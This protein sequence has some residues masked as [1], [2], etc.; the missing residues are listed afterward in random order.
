MGSHRRGLPADVFLSRRLMGQI[1]E[2]A[3]LCTTIERLGV[4]VAG[5]EYM[6]SHGQDLFTFVTEAMLGFKELFF[7]EMETEKSSAIS[8]AGTTKPVAS[9][10]LRVAGPSQPLGNM[11]SRS[12]ISPTQLPLV[13]PPPK[14]RPINRKRQRENIENEN[15]ADEAAL[16]VIQRKK[17]K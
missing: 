4:V 16:F 17:K 8:A 7:E 5:W 11:A 13:P 12:N 2:K 15:G 10:L 1:V 3:H 6:G 14:P 9:V